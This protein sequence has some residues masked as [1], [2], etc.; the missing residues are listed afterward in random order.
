MSSRKSNVNKLSTGAGV[1]KVVAEQGC[2]GSRWTLNKGGRG[3]KIKIR[4]GFC[5]GGNAV[6]VSW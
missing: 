3:K 4:T 6:P 2:L 5:S 1:K